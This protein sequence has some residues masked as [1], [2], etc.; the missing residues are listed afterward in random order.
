MSLGIGRCRSLVRTLGVVF[1][2]P[3]VGCVVLA[4]GVWSF[5]LAQVPLGFAYLLCVLALTTQTEK[6]V[7]ALRGCLC[8]R[9]AEALRAGGREACPA[10]G[11]VATD[12]DRACIERIIAK[13]WRG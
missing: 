8:H 12:A 1:A 4:S 10:W 6:R 11:H 7:R 13:G 5:A 9:C 3:A 2:V